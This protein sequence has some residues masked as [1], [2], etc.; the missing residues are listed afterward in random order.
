MYKFKPVSSLLIDQIMHAHA[1]YFVFKTDKMRTLHCLKNSFVS[2]AT[3]NN[4]T[5]Q[6]IILDPASQLKAV[7][8]KKGK[9]CQT[10]VQ[11]EIKTA[12]WYIKSPGGYSLIS[13]I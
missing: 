6:M 9:E 4:K 10:F 7:Y 5:N 3:N 2:R 1:M 8:Q 11:E 12:G 13:A